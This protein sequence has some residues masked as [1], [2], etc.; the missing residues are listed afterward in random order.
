MSREC[1]RRY[2]N[3][4][5]NV[6][7][8]KD[9]IFYMLSSKTTRKPQK[10]GLFTKMKLSL[11]HPCVLFERVKGEGIKEAFIYYVVMVLIFSTALQTIATL[12]LVSSVHGDAIFV[13]SNQ[14]LYF[15]V[16]IGAVFVFALF[17][18]VGI[19][20]LHGKGNYTDTYR[21]AVYGSTPGIVFS[22]FIL[23]PL[24]VFLGPLFPLAGSTPPETLDPSLIFSVLGAIVIAVIIGIV[25]FV[26]GLIIEVKGLSRFHKIS[27]LRAFGA[28]VIGFVILAVIALIIL[29]SFLFLVLLPTISSGDSAQTRG[30]DIT[31]TNPDAC[32]DLS[33]D[34][35]NVCY[36]FVAANREDPS[37]CEKITQLFYKNDCYQRLAEK[38]GDVSFCDKITTASTRYSCYD[39]LR[40]V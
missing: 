15:L 3:L 31:S 7:I 37:L 5:K 36:S 24:Y 39:E 6:F 12:S 1:A 13:L 21:A 26:W 19:R 25:L 32:E 34:K 4:S 14:I 40:L 35:Q 11:L 28:I 30:F 23:L 2:P 17:T 29:F 8:L 10:P 22:I 33:A 38:T 18:H 16:S 27:G 20:L 9:L